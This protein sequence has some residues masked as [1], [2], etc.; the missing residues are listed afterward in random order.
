VWIRQLVYV[1]TSIIGRSI[2]T[3][4]IFKV[5]DTGFGGFCLVTGPSNMKDSY[6]YLGT[7]FHPHYQQSCVIAVLLSFLALALSP[8]VRKL[9]TVFAQELVI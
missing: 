8:F 4:N 7:V 1:D 5:A 2:L 9:S 6:L 3:R